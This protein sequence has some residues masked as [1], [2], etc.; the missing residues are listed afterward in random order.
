MVKRGF[1][2]IYTGDGKGKT[3][4]ALGLVIRAR[5]HGLKVCYVYFFRNFDRWKCGEHGILKKVGI[6]IFGF[7][8]KHPHFY[9]NV[10]KDE[11]RRECLKALEFIKKIYRKNKHDILVLDEILVSLRHGFLKEKEILEILSLKPKGMELVLTGRGGTRRIIKKA[12]L[13]SQVKNIK[14][15]YNSGIKARKGIEY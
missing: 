3:T 6:E 15:P 1:I 11:V 13:V 14:H 10:T 5:G 7:A 4:A 2:Q 12:D 8:K 9:K